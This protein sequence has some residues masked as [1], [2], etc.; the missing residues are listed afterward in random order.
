MMMEQGSS[1][2]DVAYGASSSWRY[3]S[4]AKGR[5]STESAMWDAYP[6]PYSSIIDYIIACKICRLV[7]RAYAEIKSP[8]H[9]VIDKESFEFICIK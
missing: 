5:R 1:S 7:H 8:K 2:P 4:Q 6:I 9:T 3:L